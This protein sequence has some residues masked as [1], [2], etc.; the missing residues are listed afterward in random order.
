MQPACFLR[1]TFISVSEVCTPSA[2]DIAV[3]LDLRQPT[4]HLVGVRLELTPG[5]EPLRLCLPAWTPGSYLIRDYVRHLE[6][7]EVEQRGQRWRPQRTDVASWKLELPSQDRLYI[8]YT[9]L[10]TELS[11]RTCHLDADH[12]FLALAAVV[13]LVQDQRWRPLQLSLDLPSGWDVF[14]PLMQLS[15]NTW[16]ARDFDELVDSP[17]E[18]GPHPHHSFDVAGVPHRWVSWGGDLPDLDHGWLTDVSMLCLTCCRLMGVSRPAAEQY[19]FILHLRDHGFGG[20]EHDSACVLMYGRRALAQPGG[21]RHLLQLVAHEYLHQWNVRRLRP[22][23]LS[24]YE[25]S[26]PAIIPTL[27]FAEGVTSYYDQLLPV[28]AGLCGEAELLEDL[29]GD[30]S[31]YLLTPGRAVQSL[32]QSSEEAWVKL[33]R[34]DAWSADSQISYYLK[35]AVLSLILDLHL[36]RSRVCLADVLR[37]LWQ[38]F[39]SCQR[40]Y[41]EADLVAVFSEISPDLEQLLPSWL[42]ETDDPDVH[43]YLSDIGLLLKPQLA[44]TADLG[45]VLENPDR[46]GLRLR[47]VVRNGPAAQ[48]GLQVGDELLAIDGHRILQVDDLSSVLG[49]S[50]SGR[51]LHAQLDILFCR[52]GNVRR[53]AVRLAAAGIERWILSA[54]PNA[55]QEAIDRRQR[56]MQLKPEP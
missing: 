34:Q 1:P 27:W 49:L 19:L 24:P 29:G 28:A 2:D 16:W 54:D 23:E 42:A 56:W 45:W 15:P 17:V 55:S 3:N 14:V 7:L 52:D 39:G 11:V 48:A 9:I 6:G 43:C 33:Y 37:I 30:L 31:R 4:N 46:T 8:H 25:Y 18:V 22:A 10:A 50:E 13:L 26:T 21:R 44:I 47:R 40:G 38:R 36:R 53:T 20:L 51:P 32:R 41:Q 12:C 5:P 35:G